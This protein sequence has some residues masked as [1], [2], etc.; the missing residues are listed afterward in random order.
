MYCKQCDLQSF[1]LTSDILSKQNSYI[2]ILGFQSYQIAAASW[3]GTFDDQL[4]LNLTPNIRILFDPKWC[5]TGNTYISIVVIGVFVANIPADG[6]NT[7]VTSTSHIST[8]KFCRSSN[9]YNSIWVIY[10]DRISNVKS[11]SRDYAIFKAK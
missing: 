10:C 8:C 3:S 11:Q 9:L 7:A 5:A 6:I 4:S 1:L 2:G